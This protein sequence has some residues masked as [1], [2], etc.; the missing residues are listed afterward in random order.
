[1]KKQINLFAIIFFLSTFLSLFAQSPADSL[2]ENAQPDSTEK[3]QTANLTVVI[4][5]LNNDKG[6][7]R[8]ALCNSKENYDSANP[9]MKASAKIQNNT[10]TFTFEEVPFGTYAV[11]FYHDENMN[12]K[13]DRNYFGM[14]KEDYGFS[15]NAT[16]NFGPASFEDAKF[17]ITV[18]EKT[19]TITAQ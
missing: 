18:P 1:M 15:N 5:D 19:I 17:E 10:A 3:I 16:G 13:L 9:F 11:K 7:V 12:G 2:L 6:E 14:P 4:T 8:I